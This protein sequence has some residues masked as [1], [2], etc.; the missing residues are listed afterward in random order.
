MVPLTAGVLRLSPIYSTSAFSH[1]NFG[2]AAGLHNQLAQSAGTISRHN[3]LNEFQRNAITE[4]ANV[5]AHHTQVPSKCR[6]AN[7]IPTLRTRS[8]AQRTSREYL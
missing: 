4:R 2:Q 8:L 6:G 7:G 3:G 1:R 5:L